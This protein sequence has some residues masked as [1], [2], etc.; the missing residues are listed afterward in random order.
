MSEPTVFDRVLVSLHEAMLDDASWP[1]TAAHIVEACGAVGNELVV[2]EG[3]GDDV[4]VLLAWFYHGGRRREDLEREYFEFYHEHDERLPR[5]RQ[6][7]DGQVVH[8]R[9]LYD[10]AELRTSR[11]Y[12]EMLRRTGTRNALNVRLDGP[13]GSRI[14]WAIGDPIEGDTWEPGQIEM[15]ERLLPH[16]RQYVQIRQALVGAE[17]LGASLAELLDNTQIGVIYLDRRGRIVEANDRAVEFIGRNNGLLDRDGYLRAR[18]PTDDVNLQTI[19]AEALPSFGRGVAGGTMT[20]RRT[21]GRRRLVVHISPVTPRQAEFS[22]QRV[23]ALALIVEPG[24]HSQIDPDH[25]G[26]VLGLTPAESRVAVWLAEGRTVREIAA[27][28]RRQESSVR[29]LIKQVYN[30]QGISRQADLVRLVLSLA[31]S[32]PPRES[33]AH[34]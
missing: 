6:L 19:L 4:D 21:P 13:Y 12:N 22:A 33:Q 8:V 5:L 24:S 10:E 28:T 18:R 23:A 16:I 7:P 25:V 11:T 3:P 29:W 32:Q 9:T 31:G 20:I 34:P 2:A 14:I 30:K 27:E 1:A 15:V 26:S 17:A